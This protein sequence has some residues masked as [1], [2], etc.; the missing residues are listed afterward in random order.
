MN[1]RELLKKEMPIC[2]VILE[3]FC[4]I[5]AIKPLTYFSAQAGRGFVATKLNFSPPQILWGE[6]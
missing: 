1:T 4:D 6:K 3:Y 5:F 2:L